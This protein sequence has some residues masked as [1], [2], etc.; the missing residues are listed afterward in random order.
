MVWW[1]NGPVYW[2]YLGVWWDK[3][4]NILELPWWCGGVNGP[5]YWS[6]LGGVEG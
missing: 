1:G 3:W 2:S 6:Y 5:V 4:N